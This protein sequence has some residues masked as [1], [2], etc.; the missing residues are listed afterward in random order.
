MDTI[1]CIILT[2]QVNLSLGFRHPLCPTLTLVQRHD[3][4]KSTMAYYQTL[5]IYYFNRL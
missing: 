2:D 5:L 3:S 4:P 1:V